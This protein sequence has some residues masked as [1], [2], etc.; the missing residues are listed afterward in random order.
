VV[1]QM[2]QENTEL[3]HRLRHSGQSNHNSTA[4]NNS[5]FSNGGSGPNTS[6]DAVSAANSKLKKQVESLKRELQEL[7]LAHEKLRTEAAREVSRWKLKIG[8]VNPSHVDSAVPTAATDSMMLPKGVVADLKR[9]VLV[10][11]QE[12]RSER[13]KSTISGARMHP[14]AISTRASASYFSPGHISRYTGRDREGGVSSVTR[15]THSWA[16]R[17]ISADTALRMRSRGTSGVVQQRLTASTWGNPHGSASSKQ[18]VGSRR[19]SPRVPSSSSLGGSRF[20]P[21]AYQ[22]QKQ[23][24]KELQSMSSKAWGVGVSHRD[25]HR[26]RSPNGLR[27]ESGYSSANSQVRLLT[28]PTL[29]KFYL[30]HLVV[31]CNRSVHLPLLPISPLH[32]LFS[33]PMAP[34]GPV[35]PLLQ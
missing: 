4:T 1:S 13:L 27:H 29:L 32:P 6:A 19:A 9:R 23:Q 31:G 5:S 17:S 2:R 15:P 3:K 25:K 20:D 22:R 10:L 16:S 30:H 21:T 8:S 26:Y 11:E 35:V 7:S 28:L 34:D 14:A 33:L 24:L 18:A 12:L